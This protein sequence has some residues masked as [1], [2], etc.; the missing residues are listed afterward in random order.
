VL[1]FCLCPL[2]FLCLAGLWLHKGLSGVYVFIER[3]LAVFFIPPRFLWVELVRSGQAPFWN[4]FNY[5]GIPLLATLQ[6]GILYP[7]NAL[8]L[9]LPFPIA[10]N[11]LI[12]LHFVLAGVATHLFLRYLRASPAAAFLGGL[13]FMLSGYLLS[14]HNLLPHL[15]AVSWFPLTLMAHL[16]FLD[17]RRVCFGALAALSLSMEFLAG[18]PEI[19]IMTLLVLVVLTAKPDPFF[20]SMQGSTARPAKGLMLLRRYGMLALVLILFLLVTGVQ[21]LP[22]QELSSWSI[23]RAGLP[24][25]EAVTWSLGWKDLIQ[26]FLPDPYGYGASTEKYWA[27]QSWLKT[28]YLG[29]APFLL[30]LFFFMTRDRRSWLLLGLMLLGLFLALGGNTPLY[31]LL[32]LLPAFSSI[33]YPVKFLFLF[34]FGIAVT[35]GLGFDSLRKGIEAGQAGTTR[36]VRLVFYGGFAFAVG[37]G[38]MN[39]FDTEIRGFMEGMNWKPGRFNDIT[40]NMYHAKRFLLFSFMFC[41]SLLLWLRVS[42]KRVA[43]ALVITLVVA[44]LFVANHG[45]YYVQAWGQYRQSNGLT[46]LLAENGGSDRYV[47]TPQS[48]QSRG[49]DWGGLHPHRAAVSGLYAIDGAEVLKVFHQNRFLGLTMTTGSLK[50]ATRYFDISGVRYVVTV[51]RIEDA[52]RFRLL[53]QEKVGAGE[54]YLYEYIHYPG[55]FLFFH[56]IYSAKDDEDVLSRLQDPGFDLRRTLILQGVEEGRTEKASPTSNGRVRLLTYKAKEVVLE[57]DTDSG[58]F[59]YVSDTYYPGW[60]ASVDGKRT[61]IYRANLAFRAVYVPAGEHRIVFE[62]VPISFY[63]GLLLSVIGL[64]LAAILLFRKRPLWGR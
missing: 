29:I 30:S 12:I 32:Y 48:E 49:I 25:K 64:A 44:D 62:Y 42:Y 5:S 38:L 11:W 34:V 31:R 60:R 54:V 15:F 27:N 21:L 40:Y 4:P 7:P 2:G 19:V 47:L 61:Q 41:I 10:W 52:Q 55:R 53:R 43:S 3:D 23:R 26:F 45:L 8:F 28:I 63:W 57:C 17:T 9:I 59:L 1:S 22:F 35:A 24:Y 50:E 14:V 18:A 51:Y 33:R 20:L 16:R 13:I 37:W 39:L 46:S 58:G 6:P 56:D 36:T